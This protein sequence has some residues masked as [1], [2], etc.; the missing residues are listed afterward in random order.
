[1]KELKIVDLASPRFEDGERWLIAGMSDRYTF[2][3]ND[4]IPA[5]WQT[6]IPYIGNIPGQ[7]GGVTYGV[8]CNPGADGSFEYI[9]GVEVKR[10]DRLPA[11]FRCIELEPQRYA[12]FEHSGHLSTIHQTFHSIWNGWLPTSGFKA[13]EAPEFERYSE[14]YDPVAGTGV[15]EIWLPVE[16]S[17]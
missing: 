7:V 5:L 16:R 17:A 10:C 9:A 2:E 3:T 11:P 14:D 1:M 15:L 4:G 13:A 8:C 12:V 6:F